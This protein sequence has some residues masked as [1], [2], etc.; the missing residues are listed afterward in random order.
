[1]NYLFTL[2]YYKKLMEREQA[3]KRWEKWK[4]QRAYYQNRREE[5][6]S[7]ASNPNKLNIMK[8]IIGQMDRELL[9]QNQTNGKEIKLEK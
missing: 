3:S 7:N 6:P 1:M 9:S 4:N 8:E 5:E 2:T